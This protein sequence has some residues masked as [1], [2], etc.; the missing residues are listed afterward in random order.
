MIQ[1]Q[2]LSQSDSTRL[3][4]IYENNSRRNAEV[5]DSFFIIN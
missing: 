2:Y 4:D 5:C 1:Q 3:S